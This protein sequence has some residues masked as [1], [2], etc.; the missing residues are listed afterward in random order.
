M[1]AADQRS[2]RFDSYKGPSVLEIT[3]NYYALHSAELM[4]PYQRLKE[5][6][7]RSF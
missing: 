4:D 7:S 3:G 5:L 1:H 2:I 6:S